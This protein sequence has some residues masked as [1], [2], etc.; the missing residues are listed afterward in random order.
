[1]R[2][3]HWFGLRRGQFVRWAVG[4]VER[5]VG[6]SINI[7]VGRCCRVWDAVLSKQNPPFVFV[8]SSPTREGFIESVEDFDVSES[9]RCVNGRCNYKELRDHEIQFSDN[10]WHYVSSTVNGELT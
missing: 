4:P 8:S 6:K 7:R 2:R 1:V 10:S 3:R 9:M 5:C